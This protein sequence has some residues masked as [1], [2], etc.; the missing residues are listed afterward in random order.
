MGDGIRQRENPIV[1]QQ[2]IINLHKVT[3]TYYR[4]VTIYIIDPVETLSPTPNQG[5]SML[6]VVRAKELFEKYDREVAKDGSHQPEVVFKSRRDYLAEG[7]TDEIDAE[8]LARWKRTQDFEDRM[9]SLDDY[10]EQALAQRKDEA[11]ILYHQ[12]NLV[13]QTQLIEEYR[14]AAFAALQDWEQD[15]VQTEAMAQKLAKV[16][17]I[18]DVV[19]DLW[20]HNPPKPYMSHIARDFQTDPRKVI[21]DLYSTTTL[22]FER[23]SSWTLPRR[24]TA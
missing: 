17:N 14:V 15:C 3:R 16:N 20:Y 9:E 21:S 2:V 5:T 1:E 4:K 13:S 6:S 23:K 19:G 10:R 8:E 11:G 18:C 12:S 22:R 7:V 24:P